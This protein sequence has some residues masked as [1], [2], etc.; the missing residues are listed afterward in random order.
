MQISKKSSKLGYLGF[1][2]ASVRVFLNKLSTR[3]LYQILDACQK[4]SERGI[5]RKFIR[6]GIVSED[7]RKALFRRSSPRSV[8]LL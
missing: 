8:L 4:L 7:L 2:E 5:G 3:F 1:R 6:H